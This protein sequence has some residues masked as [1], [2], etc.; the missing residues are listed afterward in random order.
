MCDA[1]RRARF[2]LFVLAFVPAKSARQVQAGSEICVDGIELVQ[3]SDLRKGIWLARTAG[4]A[5]ALDLIDFKEVASLRFRP[6][7]PTCRMPMTNNSAECQMSGRGQY[8]IDSGSA[9][10]A[11]RVDRANLNNRLA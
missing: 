3:H 8:V 2:R 7:L 10:N 11:I 1:F 6:A 4:L 9:A 5:R